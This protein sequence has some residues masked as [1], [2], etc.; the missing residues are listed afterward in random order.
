VGSGEFYTVQEFAKL[1]GVT[2]RALHHYDRVGLLK[3]GRTSRGY[4]AYF[5]RDLERLEQIVALKFIGL[6]LKEIKRVLDRDPLDLSKA[7]RQQRAAI[8]EKKHLLEA[9]IRAITA[10]DAELKSG[11]RP[12]SSALKKIIEVIEMQSNP[13]WIMKYFS[14]EAKAKVEARKSAWTPEMQVRAEQDWSDLFRDIRLALGKDPA[15]AE[16]QGLLD[17]WNNLVREFTGGE[18]GVV[19]GVKLLYSDRANW[20]VRFQEKMAPFSDERVWEYFRKTVAARNAARHGE[21]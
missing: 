1:S 3:P 12:S 4:R 10:G 9:A 21:G 5:D 8:E 6:P 7:L 15:S 14:D 11:K 13:D 20:P 18:P 17:R 16:A 19:K 2:V